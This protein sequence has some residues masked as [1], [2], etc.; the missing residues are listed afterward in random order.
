MEG[1]SFAVIRLFVDNRY[2]VIRFNQHQKVVDK[3]QEVIRTCN[4]LF[5]EAD[6][7]VLTLLFKHRNCGDYCCVLKNP[8]CYKTCLSLYNNPLFHLRK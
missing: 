4:N 5:H 1:Y 7:L 2:K 8:W 6:Q 3:W